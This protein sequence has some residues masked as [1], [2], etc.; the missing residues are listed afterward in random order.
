MS[1]FWSAVINLQLIQLV[2]LQVEV[3]QQPFYKYDF[4]K[5]VI[6]DYDTYLGDVL[7]AASRV[8]KDMLNLE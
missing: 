4:P 2:S 5:A 8:N 3:L 7:P 1:C 6:L